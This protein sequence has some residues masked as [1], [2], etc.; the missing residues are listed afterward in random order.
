MQAVGPDPL[1]RIFAALAD[2]TRRAMLVRLAG[3]D[4]SIGDLGRPFGLSK[5]A[6]TKHIRVLERAGLVRRGADPGDR[7]IMRMSA[8]R[9]ALRKAD[10][11]LR[12]HRR[13]WNDRLDA[14]EEHL[15]RPRS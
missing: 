1:D 15:A 11:W 7:R 6:I 8:D 13:F 14:L 4:A 5:P 3:R 10:A 9:A 2:P 12:F